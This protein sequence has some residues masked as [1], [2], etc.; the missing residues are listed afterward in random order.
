MISKFGRVLLLL[1][2][3]TAACSGILAQTEVKGI[4]NGPDGRP[5]SGVTLRILPETSETAVAF[6]IT[7]KD[8]RFRLR[9]EGTPNSRFRLVAAALNLKP[10]TLTLNLDGMSGEEP[11]GPL[12]IEMAPSVS[13]MREV[14]V[15]S[16]RPVYRRSGD[17]L[18]YD[19]ARFR[20]L[21]TTKLEDLLS[22]I[23][24][25]EVGQDGRIRYNG[26]EIDRILI[27]GE[28]LAERD[29]RLISRNLGAKIVDKVQV[30]QDFSVDR[31][32][33]MVQRSGGVGINLTIDS[34]HRGKVTGA[35]EAGAGIG[36]REWLDNSAIR[37][38]HRLKSMA[39]LRYSEIGGSSAADL[40]HQYNDGDKGE[41]A[42]DGLV[43]PR[44]VET[45]TVPLP[46]LD[47]TYAR[48]HRD[49][50][51]HVM[52]TLRG[53]KG[54]RLKA[55]LGFD[56][57]M[58]Q[59]SAEATDTHF[60]PDGRNWTLSQHTRSRSRLLN[61][62]GRVGMDYD[63]GLNHSGRW[64]LGFHQGGDRNEFSDLASGAVTDTLSERLASDRRGLGF[65]GEHLAKLASGTVLKGVFSLQRE[66]M[67]RLFDVLTTRLSGLSPADT[68]LERFTQET[69]AG[70]S[71]IHASVA[72]H[73]SRK[74]N[75][76]R[77]GARL[78]IYDLAQGSGGSARRADGS[79]AVELAVS[80]SDLSIVRLEGFGSLE[81]RLS[82]KTS[83]AS[84]LL[85][86]Y[87]WSR[88]MLDGMAH[89]A[90]FPYHTLSLSLRRRRSLLRFLT[91]ELTS[92]RGIPAPE[93]FHPTALLTGEATVRWPAT[94]VSPFLRQTMR[95]QHVSNSLSK[96][97][98]FTFGGSYS[99]SDGAF[100]MSLE[101]TPSMLMVFPQPMPPSGMA[102][103]QGRF[104]R[105]LARPRLKAGLTGGASVMHERI[106]Y[107]SVPVLRLLQ[108]CHMRVHAVTVYQ[109]RADFEGSLQAAFVRDRLD[110]DRGEST[111]FSQWNLQGHVK[112]RLRWSDRFTASLMDRFYLLDQSRVIHAVDLHA[113]YSVSPRWRC[114]LIGHNLLDVE[115]LSQ[116]MPGPGSISERS[117]ALVGRFIQFR[118]SFDF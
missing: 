3:L 85:A 4:V 95:F 37:V 43:L 33:R 77:T 82:G 107:N 67:T 111:V 29:Y 51:G 100:S 73:G 83:L 41:D 71:A 9:F 18:E 109:G 17:T 116:R 92:A 47:A 28:D 68:A 24:G 97:R 86:G 104:E 78:L 19:A 113:T 115:R 1:F 101:R 31:L 70:I 38:G 96:G 45:G 20:T 112:C 61:L 22:G 99:R 58:L 15:R 80:T 90:G 27:E 98:E 5:Q 59:N 13:E 52:A 103:V 50:A 102:D 114:S 16:L 76:W 11:D 26:R 74:N 35:A 49:L 2:S 57:A 34:L 108:T 36:E 30:L 63:R 42:E 110:P 87:A 32:M 93:F 23:K 64:R 118:V 81:R 89:R 66:R 56:R 10:D 54:S 79:G 21:E 39:F 84:S 44:T 53:R 25:F 88:H 75:D 14:V 6:G 105:Y 65:R 12:V 7:G 60:M 72:M 55:L 106:V 46:P 8:G 62:A 48:D 117:M 40:E 91:V 69:E 94:Q